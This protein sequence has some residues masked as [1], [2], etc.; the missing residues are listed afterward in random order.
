MFKPKPT[1]TFLDLFQ[2]EIKPFARSVSNVG[3]KRVR[4]RCNSFS[5]LLGRDRTRRAFQAL[6]QP[7]RRGTV[8]V[9]VAAAFAYPFFERRWYNVSGF[10]SQ[11]RKKAREMRKATDRA[12]VVL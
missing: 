9:Y 1:L 6:S 3:C 2:A 12:D 10:A 5:N 11:Q 4:T 7:R 8:H